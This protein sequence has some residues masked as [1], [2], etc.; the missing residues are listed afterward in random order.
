MN[1]CPGL[2]SAAQH[3]YS[4]AD[5]AEGQLMLKNLGYLTDIASLGEAAEIGIEADH[6]T[7]RCRATPTFYWG[8]F[9][10]LPRAPAAERIDHWLAVFAGAFGD[11]PRIGHVSIGWQD[12]T[13]DAEAVKRFV[14]RG[15]EVEDCTV[16]TLDSPPPDRALP[17]GMRIEVARSD[18]DWRA[19]VELG[20]ACRDRRHGEASFRRYLEELVVERRREAEAGRLHWYLARID[21][22]VAGDMGLFVVDRAPKGLAI[23]GVDAPLPLA[24]FQAVKTHP[25]MRGRGVCSALLTRVCRDGLGPMGLKR[26]VILVDESGPAWRIYRRHG[27]RPLGKARGV[28][29]PPAADWKAGAGGD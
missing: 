23:D 6:M 8:N 20:M 28:W 21:G 9:L 29:R 22:R 4:A 7:V 27:F 3:P 19:V 11:D 12:D 25:D 24:R 26:L 18:A 5:P 2:F 13:G 15:F 17:T 16:T 1:I 14:E 10:L